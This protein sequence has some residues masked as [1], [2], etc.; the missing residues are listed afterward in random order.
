MGPVYRMTAAVVMLVAPKEPSCQATGKLVKIIAVGITR[1]FS[2][3]TRASYFTRRRA[4]TRKRRRQPGEDTARRSRKEG[5]GAA[6]GGKSEAKPRKSVS[7]LG[8]D[9]GRIC[10]LSE[11]PLAPHRPAPEDHYTPRK[12]VLHSALKGWW[13][14]KGSFLCDTLLLQISASPC[15]GELAN[16][17]RNAAL[18]GCCRQFPVL[19]G[20]KETDTLHQTF[21][22]ACPQTGT[23]RAGVHA[24]LRPRLLQSRCR[25]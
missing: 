19:F 5:K 24:F 18:N 23:G 25:R 20:E 7:T 11:S 17:R 3:G 9:V 16:T 4:A 14:K 21:K 1:T 22:A 12:L 8:T 2:C 15:G 13:R 10:C 6:G